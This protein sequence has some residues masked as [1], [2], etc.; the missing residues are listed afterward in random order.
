[1]SLKWSRS[2]IRTATESPDRSNR[3]S[4]RSARLKNSARLPRP[5]SA[6]RMAWVCR[7]AASTA[8]RRTAST[9]IASSGSI[10]PLVWARTAATPDEAD[11]HGRGLHLERQV[12]AQHLHDGLA[13]GQGDDDRDQAVVDRPGR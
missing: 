6:S 12:V 11:E 1:M 10:Q 13:G 7:A 2:I 9:G 8:E 3:A 4:S 5:V